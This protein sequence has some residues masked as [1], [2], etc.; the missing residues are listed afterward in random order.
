MNRIGEEHAFLAREVNESF[1]RVLK[2]LLKPRRKRA[3]KARRPRKGRR[4]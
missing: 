4:K 2:D 1:K 3:K